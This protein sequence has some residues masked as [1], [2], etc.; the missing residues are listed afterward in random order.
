VARLSRYS[1]KSLAPGQ[2]EHDH[3]NLQPEAAA[4]GCDTE[5]T[6]L[7]ELQRIFPIKGY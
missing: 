4:I 5:A 7:E 2:P 3:L 6:T 1:G